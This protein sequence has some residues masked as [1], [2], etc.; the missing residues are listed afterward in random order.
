M[1]IRCKAVPG[2][3]SKAGRR[4]RS[5]GSLIGSRRKTRGVKDAR[6]PC[7]PE[8]LQGKRD[9]LIF[10]LLLALRNPRK[11][12]DA[13][14]RSECSPSPPVVVGPL[15][16]YARRFT[17]LLTGPA[18]LR[19]NTREGLVQRNGSMRESDS[20]GV[21]TA[22]RT[23]ECSDPL[24]AAYRQ[25]PTHCGLEALRGS[26]AVVSNLRVVPRARRCL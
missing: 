18:L 12:V 19:A 14:K 7:G 1:T 5:G 20:E 25:Q 13:R 10:L 11:P 2:S 6:S 15:L 8:Q 21:L 22:D 26:L 16:G 24:S 23:T 9:S 17:C 3:G 4:Q